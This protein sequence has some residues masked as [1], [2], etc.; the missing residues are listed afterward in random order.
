MGIVVTK[1]DGITEKFHQTNQYDGEGL[2]YETE[3]NGK[4]IRFLFDR[5]ELAHESREK[6]KISYARGYQPI[7]LSRNGKDR[8]YFVQD[9]M[10]ST[11]FLLDHNHEIQKTYRYDAFGNIL[12]E[13]G[14]LSNRLTYTGQMYD[15]AAGQYYLRARFY[16]PA[17]G[18]FLQEDTYRGDGLNL[19]A[20]CANNP[21]IY[22]DPSGHGLWPN[23]KTYPAKKEEL[24][25]DMIP[26]PNGTMIS[27]EYDQLVYGGFYTDKA[28]NRMRFEAQY[29]PGIDN[30]SLEYK[31][32]FEGIPVPHGNGTIYYFYDTGQVIGFD[33]LISHLKMLKM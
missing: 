26:G 7:S 2:R 14:E 33:G 27:K 9:E 25:P 13:M 12:K 8:N 28:Y 30:N 5:G 23:G 20:Y 17:V 18:R 19:Y 29:I 16:N 1:D 4:V 15:G 32:M 10:G 24:V 11:L 3:E 6:E 21:V 22:Y 31:A